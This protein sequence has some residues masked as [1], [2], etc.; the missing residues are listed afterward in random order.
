M[1]YTSWESASWSTSSADVL[2]EDGNHVVLEVVSA[3]VPNLSNLH[4]WVVLVAAAA[5]AP[6]VVVAAAVAEAEVVVVGVDSEVALTVV[7][8]AS[9]EAVAGS[10]EDVE[11]DLETGVA[12]TEVEEDS[13]AVEVASEE[14][15]MTLG[16]PEVEGAT[17][18]CLLVKLGFASSDVLSCQ[19]QRWRFRIPR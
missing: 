1:A 10:V 11:E 8:A 9:V 2:Y 5:P 18:R 7:V 17:G 15:V 4:T 19:R 6:A 13:E 14:A 12:S 16:R 3:A